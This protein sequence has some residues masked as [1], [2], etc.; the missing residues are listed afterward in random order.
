MKALFRKPLFII[1][2]LA[3][4]FAG[5]GI[6]F[7]S[8]SNRKSSYEFATVKKGDISQEV[9]VTGRVKAAE[10]VDLAFERSGKVTKINV[11]VGSKVTAGQ[12]LATLDNSD[13]AAQVSQARAS[14]A[15][16]KANLDALVRGTRPEEIQIAETTV[17]NAQKSLTDYQTSLTNVKNKAE[18]DLNSIYAGIKDILSDAYVKADDAVNKQ[19]DDLFN[20]DSSADPVLTFYT[21]SQSGADAEWKRRLAGLELAQLKTE[22][23][24]LPGDKAGLDDSLAKAENHLK[25]IQDF[26]N[27]LSLAVNESVGL[28]S[29]TVANYKYY[30]NT[31][32]TNVTTAIASINTK[33]QAIV[34]QKSTNQSNITTAEN[35]VNTAKNSLVAAQDQLLLKRAGSTQEQI[36]AQSAQVQSAQANLESYQ[37]QLSKT[38]IVSPING[39]VTRQDVKVGQIVAPNTAMI[40]VMSAGQFEIEANVSENEIAKV[41][42]GDLV[43]MTLDALGPNEKFVGRIIEIDPAET[44]VSGVI[45][46]KVTSVF[47]NEDPKIK[48]SMTVNLDIQTEKKENVLILPYY[49]V[50]GANDSKY[51]RVLE[52]GKEK[53]K[54]IKTGLEGETMIEIIEGLKEGDEV[55]ASN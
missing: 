36:S 8:S 41:S 32:R 21:G 7:Y 24:S 29:T 55:I 50:K 39:L 42:L 45:Y 47:N 51:V 17:T 22:I 20:N 27:A 10:A 1:F 38:V 44:I 33:E 15:V 53:E 13:L 11:G 9:S 4:I 26:L 19:I 6:Y 52:N 49:V 46:Y 31:G 5:V 16:Q 25:V 23:D 28:T 14:L 3:V 35:A 48:S 43:N 2:V 12:I 30:V 54:I 37:A 40:S 18:S 34:T